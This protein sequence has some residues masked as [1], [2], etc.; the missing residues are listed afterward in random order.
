MSDRAGE[1]EPGSVSSGAIVATSQASGDHRLLLDIANLLSNKLEPELLFDTIALIVRQFLNIDRASIALYDSERDEFEIV[2]IALQEGTQFGKGL[3]IPHTGSRVGKAFDTGQPLLSTLRSSS[4][5]YEDPPLLKDGMHTGLVLPMLADGKPI[6]TF[7]VNF[8]EERALSQGDVDLLGKIANQIGIAVANTRAFQHIRTTTEGLKRENEYLLQLMQPEESSLFLDTPSLRRSLDRLMTLAKV[9]ATVLIT[10]E[11]GTGKGVLARALHGW[12][13]RRKVPFVKCDC[14]ALMPSLIESELFGHEKGAFTGAHVRR[15][16]RFELANGGTLFLDE[17]GEMPLQTQVKLLG[18]LQ[19][20]QVQRV[21]GTRSIPVDIRVIAAS[22]RDL[23]GEV[24]AGTVREDLYYRL[25][26]LNVHLLPLRER[27]ED[28]LPLATHFI[29]GFNRT[30]GRSVDSIG[31]AARAALMSYEWP[32]NIR[33]LEN[34]VERAVLLSRGSV[35]EIDEVLA[36][37]AQAVLPAPCVERRV[38]PLTL[39]AVEGRHIRAILEETEWRIA[40]PRGAA[41]ILG[42]HPNTLRSRMEKLGIRR[43]AS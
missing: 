23:R 5:F 24:E 7:N 42:M 26:V 3:S 28:I 21:G 4:T 39:A 40:G 43:G 17:I 31:P 6:G 29:R 2:A 15:I 8:R 14:A 30:L 41:K 11:T 13:A 12:S 18:V 32:G 37:G 27:T 20:R 36:P 33:E 25:N 10:G 16:G 9:D 22:N 35:L 38:E 1:P 34:V 19:D